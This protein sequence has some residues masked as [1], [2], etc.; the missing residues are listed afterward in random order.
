MIVV[1]I[2]N[3]RVLL[4]QGWVSH[5]STHLRLSIGFRLTCDV[6]LP[7]QPYEKP[8]TTLQMQISTGS[9]KKN[10]QSIIPNASRCLSSPCT[11]IEDDF[12]IKLNIWSEKQDH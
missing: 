6:C 10:W 7:S 4:K 2:L 3:E 8:L 11:H 12:D 1:E 5:N 9:T